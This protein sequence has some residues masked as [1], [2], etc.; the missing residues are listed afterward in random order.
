[1]VTIWTRKS[2]SGTPVGNGWGLIETSIISTRMTVGGREFILGT[3]RHSERCG[4]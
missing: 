4:L 1:M 3:W 2:K